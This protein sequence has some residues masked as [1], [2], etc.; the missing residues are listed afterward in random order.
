MY[1][2]ITLYLKTPFSLFEFNVFRILNSVFLFKWLQYL[3]SKNAIYIRNSSARLKKISLSN[4]IKYWLITEFKCIQ[5]IPKSLKYK[6]R[7]KPKKSIK[8]K[9]SLNTFKKIFVFITDCKFMNKYWKTQKDTR[10]VRF[11]NFFSHNILNTVF[12]H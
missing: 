11:I 3:F 12:R 2:Y 10:W 9:K 5:F 6:F 4:I 8:N 1:L 7:K